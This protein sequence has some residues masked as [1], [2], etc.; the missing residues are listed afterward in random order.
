MRLRGN[1]EYDKETE[2]L[3]RWQI[4]LMQKHLDIHRRTKTALQ[5]IPIRDANNVKKSFGLIEENSD[6]LSNLRGKDLRLNQYNV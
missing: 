4:T 2:K 5:S 1:A 3:L 6:N